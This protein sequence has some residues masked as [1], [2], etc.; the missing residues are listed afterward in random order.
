MPVTINSYGESDTAPLPDN[1]EDAIKEIQELRERLYKS[2]FRLM[3]LWM[4]KVLPAPWAVKGGQGASEQ[5]QEA[6]G[7][8]KKGT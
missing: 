6:L 8:V 4:D 7:Y 5:R 3:Q 1:L 2:N